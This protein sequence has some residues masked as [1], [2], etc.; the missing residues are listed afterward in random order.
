[1][2]RALTSV[3]W[4][5]NKGALTIKIHT[6]KNGVISRGKGPQQNRKYSGAQT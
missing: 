2:S 6:S 3:N 1:M 4:A 5:I